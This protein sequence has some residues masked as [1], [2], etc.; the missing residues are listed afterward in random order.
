MTAL[1]TLTMEE[2]ERMAR[3]KIPDSAQD[4]QVYYV[5]G[6]MDDLILV[7]FTL[8]ATELDAFLKSAGYPTELTDHGW[9][10]FVPSDHVPWWPKREE[11]FDNPEKSFAGAEVQEMEIGFVRKI[12]VDQTDLELFIIYLQ[13]FE[14]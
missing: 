11:Y 8:P 10:R 14:T 1:P 5:T 2:I 9:P 4:I 12:L 13:H 3:I 7:K 6:G